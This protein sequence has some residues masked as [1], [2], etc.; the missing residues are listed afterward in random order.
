[1]LPPM[2]VCSV[3][4]MLPTML[5]ERTTMPRTTPRFRTVRCPGR[6][7]PVVTSVGLI[8][9][10][11]SQCN[12]DASRLLGGLWRRDRACALVQERDDQQNQTDDKETGNAIDATERFEIDE[13]DL[14]QGHAEQR[15]R[16]V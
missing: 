1:M 3:A 10:M 16:K 11:A 7:K 13:E 15:D 5:R 2:R 12:A 8:V 14:N 6:S 4:P 9:A